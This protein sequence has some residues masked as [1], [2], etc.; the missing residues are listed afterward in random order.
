MKPVVLSSFQEGKLLLTC[1]SMINWNL[2][3]RT[4]Q[5]RGNKASI[6]TVGSEAD[7]PVDPA[8]HLRP[9]LTPH[10]RGMTPP[11]EKPFHL[12]VQSHPWP[13][14]LTGLNFTF[15]EIYKCLFLDLKTLCF[16][17]QTPMVCGAYRVQLVTWV[18]ISSNSVS[19]G[20]CSTIKGSYFPSRVKMQEEQIFVNTSNL[21]RPLSIP[22]LS[23]YFYLETT[24]YIL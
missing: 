14:R 20:G 9:D 6:L 17:G 2:S 5:P 1:L 15:S 16:P 12:H 22:L 4:K 23:L 8:V 24:L 18:I 11:R 13:P 21:E 7:H 19:H 3:A 10:L